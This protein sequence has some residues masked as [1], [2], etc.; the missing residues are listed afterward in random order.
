MLGFAHAAFG[1]NDSE[2]GISTELGTT[3]L[4][5]VRPDCDEALVAAGLLEQSEA[6]LQR[7][8][9]KV[10]YGGGIR[11][12][13]RFLSRPVRGKRVA[14]RAGVGQRGP[15]GLSLRT[16]IAKSIAPCCSAAT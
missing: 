11:P 3:A 9:A 2:D 1:A 6:Y 13:E 5:M 14:G 10:I 15:A 12:L 7:R 16:A 8:E 4:L